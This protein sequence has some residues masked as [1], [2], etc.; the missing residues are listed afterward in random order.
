MNET[1]FCGIRKLD[2]GVAFDVKSLI[3]EV[4]NSLLYLILVLVDGDGL[5][6]F[7]IEG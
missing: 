5:V 2:F 6:E 1:L 3:I 4:E 7:D